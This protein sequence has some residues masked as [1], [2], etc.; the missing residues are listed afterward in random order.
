MNIKDKIKGNIIGNNIR[1]YSPITIL[2]MLHAI[3]DDKGE[4]YFN[5]NDKEFRE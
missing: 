1:I 3:V 2:D 5:L 4:G